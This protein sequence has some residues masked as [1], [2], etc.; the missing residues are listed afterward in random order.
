M[1]APRAPCLSLDL[2]RGFRAAA[3][4]LSFTRAAHELF[5]T[6]S[7]ISHEV[8]TLEAQLGTPL[9]ARATRSLRLTRAGEQLYRAADEALAL[10]DAAAREVTGAARSLT[11]TTTVPLASLWLTPRLP[12][13]LRQH[14]E[15]GLRVVASND[16]LDLA[17]EHID[18]AIRYAATGT[19]PPSPAKLFDFDVFPVCS[20]AL[21]GNRDRPIQAVDDL[22]RHPRL[23]FETVRGGRGWYDWEQWQTAK[24]I[25]GLRSAGV[26][27]FSHYD[28]VVAAA[29]A[30]SG[31]AIGK[32][33]YLEHQLQQGVL[34]AP[35]GREGTATIGSFHLV[36]ADAAAASG[37]E[38][39]IAWL[40]SE[41]QRDVQNRARREQALARAA[42]RRTNSR[43]R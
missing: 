14:S 30:G 15:V 16:N 13:F 20:P 23:E 37:A 12:T 24:Q 25:R 11:I 32:W 21:A 38:S 18:L 9:F 5:V 2:L 7:A 10:V 42:S 35:L 29:I 19:A 31:V 4:H 36:Q 33:P 22:A 8:K 1:K 26:L 40:R 17:R 3:R 27:R 28:Q 34:V 43:R 41:A 6:Q 39:F